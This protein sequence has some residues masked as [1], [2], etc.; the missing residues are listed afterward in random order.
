MGEIQRLHYVLQT[1]E[2]SVVVHRKVIEMSGEVFSRQIFY[3][4]VSSLRELIQLKA[5]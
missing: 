3:M 1:M 2:E 5:P 4:N